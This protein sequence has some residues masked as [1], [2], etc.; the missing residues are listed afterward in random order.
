MQA[1]KG[2]LK[3][4]TNLSEADLDAL[5]N[6]VGSKNFKLSWQEALNFYKSRPDIS[7]QE[8]QELKGSKAVTLFKE[9]N[10]SVKSSVKNKKKGK[11]KDKDKKGGGK[12][13]KEKGEDADKPKKENLKKK[14]ETIMEK[15]EINGKKTFCKVI[16]MLY[17]IFEIQCWFFNNMS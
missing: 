7:L 8:F 4:L 9:K 17:I 3:K 16:T 5:I 13:K 12:K 10:D 2:L 6:F 14:P 15:T 11:D 1:S